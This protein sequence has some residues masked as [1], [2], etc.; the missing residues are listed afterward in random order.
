MKRI[1]EACLLET[2]RFFQKIDVQEGAQP[3][4]I[5]REVEHYKLS[6]ERKHV[7]FCVEEEIT[8]EDGSIILKIRRQYN[9][10]PV[11]EYIKM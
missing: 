11:G 1:Q 6:L 10:Y 3:Q 7:P 5:R 4:D 8:Q 2:V 9:S